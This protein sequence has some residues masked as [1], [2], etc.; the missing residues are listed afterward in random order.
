[1]WDLW[2]MLD[3]STS[4]TDKVL[5]AGFY[6]SV[7]ASSFGGFWSD[8]MFYVTDSHLQTAIKLS[9]WPQF[10]ESLHGLGVTHMLI[11][12]RENLPRRQ[13]FDFVAGRNEYPFCRRL[14]DSYGT[15]MYEAGGLQLYRVAVDD[16][17]HAPQ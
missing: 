8:R 1:M 4:P 3:K 15:K 7:G 2:A 9:S 10:L 14:A 17:L 16:A 11:Y 12:D 5:A 13:G 6:N